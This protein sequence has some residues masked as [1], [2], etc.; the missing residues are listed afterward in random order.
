MSLTNAVSRFAVCVAALLLARAPAYGDALT[1]NDLYE[2]AGAGDT[3]WVATSFGLNFALDTAADSSFEWWA[4]ENRDPAPW[5]LAFGDGMA[6]VCTDATAEDEAAK[7]TVMVY[8]HASDSRSSHTFTWST[9]P[10]KE[11][12]DSSRTPTYV[13]YAAAR[14]DGAWWLACADAGLVRWDGSQA[15]ALVPGVDTT[16]FALTDFPQVSLVGTAGEPDAQPT[17]VA[18]LD[19]GPDSSYVWVATPDAVWELQLSDTTWGKLSTTVED[20]GVSLEAFLDVHVGTY[21]D[22]PS[23]Y[24]TA[25]ATR[26]GRTMVVLLSLSDSGW[27]V[28]HGG[29]P[30]EAPPQAVSFAAAHQFYLADSTRVYLATDS[31]STVE[32]HDLYSRLYNDQLN[33]DWNA[34][35]VNDVHAAPN[36]D[37]THRLW[38]ATSLGLFYSPVERDG[39]LST[40]PLLFTNRSLDLDAGVDHV[41]A[42][43]TLLTD[44]AT[45]VTFKY[46][47]SK[48]AAVTI[49]VFD[50]NMDLVRTVVRDAD[51][52]AAPKGQVSTREGRDKWD[53]RNEAERTVAPGVY[54]YK[55]TTST[56]GRAFGKIVVALSR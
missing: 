16:A 18:V 14:A 6:F 45:G 56:G 41:R 20:A 23:V 24:A 43:P 35:R 34:L 10:Y 9:T 36:G 50:W 27:S 51:R 3:V 29:V 12:I 11:R 38:I 37:G 22:T 4:Y 15:R 25:E 40:E 13:C 53:G 21:A 39:E 32:K 30:G 17:G 55:V 1:S 8:D 49:Q 33:L 28:V 26:G 5:A 2:I 44:E 7:Q 52:P 48:P 42:V 46:R 19:N 54:Y 47:L 31:G